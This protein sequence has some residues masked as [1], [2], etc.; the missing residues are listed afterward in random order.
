MTIQGPKRKANS[1]YYLLALIM[2]FVL[3]FLMFLL[4][5]LIQSTTATDGYLYSPGPK[6]KE[7]RSDVEPVMDYMKPD[8]LIGEVDSDYLERVNHP[9]FLSGADKQDRVVEF[10]ASWC[11]HCQHY[12]P[13]FVQLARDVNKERP[14]PF[15]AVPCPLHTEICKE[16]GIKGYPTIKFFKAGSAEGEIIL[17]AAALPKYIIGKLSGVVKEKDHDHDHDHDQDPVQDQDQGGDPFFIKNS[18]GTAPKMDKEV[19]KMLQG[20]A[21]KW[22]QK[23]SSENTFH[24]ATLSFD[25]AVRN[26]I[27]MTNDALD[28]KQAKVL[29]KWLEL[30]NKS[31]PS[32][33]RGV[34][35]DAAVLEHQFESIIASE[36]NL[37]KYM[38]AKKEQSWSED[39]SRGV[40][41]RGY[42]CGLWE[43][44]H[45]VTVGIVQ[46]N[47]MAHDR[48]S[49]L[50]AAD[51]L[52]DY[53]E[54]Y[55][56]CDECRKNFS[57]IYDACQF[58]RCE[59][60]SSNES[61]D[62]I[63]K[64]KQL[65]LWLWETHNDVNV[66]L[67]NEERVE[68]GLGKATFE[69]EQKVRWPSKDDCSKCWLDGGGW[70]EEEV[71]LYL[72]SHYW[73]SDML[74]NKDIIQTKKDRAKEPIQGKQE[75]AAKKSDIIPVN[76]PAYKKVKKAFHDDTSS[77]FSPTIMV[78]GGLAMVV[79]LYHYNRNRR[80]YMRA[81]IAKSM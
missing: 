75:K 39:C 7:A 42:T 30:L 78:L 14:V 74:S 51:I 20:V 63:M 17:K 13:H 41:G 29:R 79:G 69:E 46:W 81:R 43:L 57:T 26:S 31:V 62:E 34:K 49:T 24:D 73:P 25:F 10:Y 72:R 68:K 65:P 71:Y 3:I 66:R 64:W 22:K 23:T 37:L 18:T 76:V 36:A 8:K 50:D 12:K 2:A 28:A 4:V 61:Y 60:L 54:N 44:F 27:F 11:G 53:I 56:T 40:K 80:R 52:K 38:P 35:E 5:S 21:Q 33:M 48:M 55:F 19:E 15:H 16:Q 1:L 67:M 6:D 58:Q 77:A 59:R 47:I 45:T 70:S 9:R 32:T